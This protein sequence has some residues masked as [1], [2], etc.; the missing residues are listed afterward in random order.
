MSKLL[1]EEAISYFD[2]CVSIST[3]DSSD[4]SAAEDASVN[5]FRDARLVGSS[6][7]LP[8]VTPY[9]SATNG[10]INCL[11]HK[12][13]QFLDLYVIIIYCIIYTNNCIT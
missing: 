10:P 4:F 6:S 1:T 9:I 8:E 12:K 2:E 5:S 13:V 3:F 11:N 7:S